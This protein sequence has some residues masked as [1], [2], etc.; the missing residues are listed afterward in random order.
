MSRRWL[1]RALIA[2]VIPAVTVPTLASS[3]TAAATAQVPSIAAVAK[4]YPHLEGGTASESAT[5]VYGPG[6]KCG[7][8]KVIKKASGRSASYS[9]DYTS[10]DPDAF[11]LTGERPSVYVQAYKFATEK[12]AIQYLH[13]YAKYAKKCPVTNPGGGNGG[14]QPDCKSSSKKIAFKLGDERWGYQMRSTCDMDGET[15]SSVMNTLFVRQG[16]FIV[17]TGAMSMD[18]TAPS[19]PKSLSLTKLALK[20]V[21]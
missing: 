11:L 16:R 3:A 8:T 5:K 4:I 14:G 6:K 7:Q 13:G 19:I 9:P 21:A 15:T 12:A 1:S 17:Y 10:G 20:S 18:A 2:L